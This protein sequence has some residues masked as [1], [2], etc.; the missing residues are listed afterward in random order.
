M[1]GGQPTVVNNT[2]GFRTTPSIVAYTKNKD[3]LVGQIAKRQAVINPKI[4]FHLSSVLWVQN[5]V[6]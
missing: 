4:L 3:L 5:I 6:N 2:E 1:E